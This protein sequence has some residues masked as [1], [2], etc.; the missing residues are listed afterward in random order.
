MLTHKR[1]VEFKWNPDSVM[2]REEAIATLTGLA[3]ELTAI[4]HP[5]YRDEYQG[6]WYFPAELSDEEA[7]LDF[8]I[9]R[10]VKLGHRVQWLEGCPYDHHPATCTVQLIGGTDEKDENFY[11]FLLGY[12]SEDWLDANRRK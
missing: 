6:D 3:R 10:I 2:E 7:W 12:R 5:G 9:D 11:P 8:A 4:A 1:V